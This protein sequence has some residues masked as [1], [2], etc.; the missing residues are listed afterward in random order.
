MDWRLV[1]VGMVEATDQDVDSPCG[2]S[3]FFKE[4]L[5][6][7]RRDFFLATPIK[8]SLYGHF[9]LVAQTGSNFRVVLYNCTGWFQENHHT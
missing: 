7:K 8:F 5:G 1:M 4:A 2:N 9:L 3:Q 6:N